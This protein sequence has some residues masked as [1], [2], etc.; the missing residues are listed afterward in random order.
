MKRFEWILLLVAAAPTLLWANSRKMTVAELQDVLTGLHNSRKSDEQIANELKQIELTEELTPAAMNSMADLVNGPFST[1]QMYVLEARSAMLAPPDTDLPKAAP[2]DAAAQQA[3][4]AKAQDYA[5]KTYPQ[6]PRLSAAHLVARFQDGVETIQSYGGINV[7]IG[8]GNDPLFEQISHYTRL[9]NTH[10]DTAEIDDG[11]EKPGGKDATPWGRNGLVNSML[12]FL[13]VDLLTSEAVSTG[14]PKFLRWE[15]I[16][17]HRTA[18]FAFAVG[19]KKSHYAIDYCCFPET[20]SVGNV[21]YGGRGPNA[22]GSA[23]FGGAGLSASPFSSPASPTISNVSDWNPFK[24]K[25]G[26]HGELFLDPDSGAVLRTIVEAEFKPSDFVHYEDIRIDYA[27]MRMGGN[28]LYVP[29]R[30][31]TNAEVVP[32]GNSFVSHFGV[33]HQYITQDYR[34]FRA[35]DGTYQV[36]ALRTQGERTVLTQGGKTTESDASLALNGVEG[37]DPDPPGGFPAIETLSRP[38]GPLAIAI[39]ANPFHRPPDDE[40]KSLLAEATQSA[41]DYW[42]SLPNFTCQQVMERFAGSNGKNNWEHIDTLTGRLD[43]FEHQEEWEFQ[44]YEKDHKKSHDS[45]SDTGRGVSEFGIFGGVIRGLFRPSAKAEISWFET[46]SLGDG[47]VQVFKYRVAKENSNLFLRASSTQVVLVGFH[48]MVYI[49]SATHGVR[50]ITQIADEV[51][52]NYP[53]HETLVSTDYDYVSIG[54]RQYLL[55]IGAQI[56]LRKGSR[57]TR[58]ELNQI[59]FSDFHRFRST[60]RIVSSTPAS[61]H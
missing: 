45:S 13:P 15:T 3:L 41:N 54:G 58:L 34:D 46:D 35:T 8:N 38:A 18:V 16:A 30:S 48:G 49:D 51:P 9:V 14:K 39:S 44:E 47:T 2:P 32:N 21:L 19:K 29:V 27:P 24:A 52:K 55:P 60:A 42:A 50:R 4:L 23:L 25:S 22:A 6:L 28:Y 43:Y 1:E 17:G 40:I 10:A 31:F 12:P 57:K 37:D 26:Y 11:M 20:S 7:K 33:R 36:A 56:V 61:V 5:A 53:I 59:R